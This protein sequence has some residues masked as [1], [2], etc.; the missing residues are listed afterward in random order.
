MNRFGHEGHEDHEEHGQMQPFDR[1]PEAAR[2]SRTAFVSFVAFV[3]SWRQPL[4][5]AAIAL[6]LTVASSAG[7]LTEAQDSPT[8]RAMADELARS[9]ASLRLPDQPAPYYIEYEVQDRASTRITARLGALVEDLTGH[10]RILRVGVRVG[11]YNFD[12]SLFNAPAGGGVVALQADGSTSAPLDDDYDAMRRQIWLATDAAYKRAVSVFARKQAAFQNRVAAEA[13]PDFSRETPQETALGGLPAVYVNRDWPQRARQ[14]SAAFADVRIIE[15][16]DV[17]VAD[18]R[19][20]RYYLNSEGFKVVAPIQIASLRI[21]AETQAG[22]GM[23]I[24]SASTL[25]EKSLR[26][27]PAVAEIS[28]RAREMAERLQAQR[29]AP[30]GDEYTGPVLVEGQ[31]SAE[32][33]AQ[34]LAPAMLARRPPESAARGGGRGGGPGQVTPFHR[35]IGLRVMAEPFSASDTPSLREFNGRTVPGAYP[36][37]DQGVRP[38][39]VTLVEKGRLLTLLT[40]RAPLKGLLQSTGHTRGGDVL[41]GVFQVQSAEAIPAA[42]LKKKYLD[43]LAVQDKPFGYIVRGIANPADS[44]GG[45]GAMITDAV[46]VTRDGREEVV[47]GLRLGAVPPATFRDLLDASRE[48]T[49]YSFR[50][51]ATDAVSVIVPDV[52]YEELEIQQAREI[53]QKPPLVR[54]PLLT[55]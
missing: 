10:S 33:V 26:D 25:V 12:S 29:A 49:L 46:K 37:D 32:I 35:R 3:S 48:R 17:S 28:A 31:A 7:R 18:T 34:S 9:M 51:T 39:D 43:L 47:R 2:V 20:T 30:L 27:L 54:S 40:G 1:P 55:D 5:A 15:S 11:D 50:G 24:R 23:V 42:E 19:G 53:M 14:I 44:P 22:D 41:P 45:G 36:V 16:S 38:K 52:I 4:A 21:S 6:G 13:I 8:M